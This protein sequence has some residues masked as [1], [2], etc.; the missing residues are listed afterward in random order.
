MQAQSIDLDGHCDYPLDT[1]LQYRCINPSVAML[2]SRI[3]VACRACVRRGEIYISESP[4]LPLRMAKPVHLALPGPAEDPRLFIHDGS[5][6]VCINVSTRR[7]R[8]IA[9]ARLSDDFSISDYRVMESPRRRPVE[10]NWQF[11]EFE[12]GLHCV[13]SVSPHAVGVVEGSTLRH[14]TRMPGFQW[15]GGEPR[16]GTPPLPFGS[17]F[18]SFFHSWIRTKGR[19]LYCA[20][21]YTFEPTPPFRI[22]RVSARPIL[23][24]EQSEQPDGPLVVY[25]CGAL[26]TEDSIAV[27]YGFHDRSS[28]VRVFS[29]KAIEANLIH[30]SPC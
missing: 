10:K 5:L 19:R 18:I 17:E 26:L 23:V 21:T 2:G 8:S 29:R 7:G 16:G 4:G 3:I 24:A 15:E 9:I 13:Y 22:N 14:L 12:G 20:G 30:P 28:R 25:P 6:W 11:F 1:G 27:T